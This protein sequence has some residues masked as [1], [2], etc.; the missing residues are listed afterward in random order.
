[1]TGYAWCSEI[2]FYLLV[3][4]T[5]AGAILAVQGRILIHALLGLAVTFIGVAGLY[6]YLG[7]PFLSM[8]Q[9]LIYLGAITIVLVF[10]T[11]IGYTPR[12]IV[13]TKIRGENLLLAVPTC[14]VAVAV[15]GIA[16]VRTHWMSAARR[17]GDFSLLRVGQSFLHDF[18]L[19]FE[20]ISLLLLIAMVGAIIVVNSQEEE[21]DGK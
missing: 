6:F 16:F 4:V 11:M 10:G 9:I 7:S 12:Q 17:I 18:C 1:M 5:L 14:V 2:L 3:A 20:L 19:A 8:M 15:M 21:R 13:E